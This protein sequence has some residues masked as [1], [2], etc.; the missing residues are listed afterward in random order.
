MK[1]KRIG[2]K[3]S[4][5][6]GFA[7]IA[8]VYVAAVVLAVAVFSLLPGQP[9]FLRILAAD[10]AATVFV[11]LA[12]M[13]VQNASVYDPYWSVQP[14]VIL[15]G[16]WLW[17]GYTSAGSALLLLVV[18]YWGVRLT[19]NWAVTFRCLAVQDW[20]YAM[21]REKYPRLFPLI[22][23][24]GIH[25]FPTVVV[26]LAVLPGVVFLQN[27]ALNFFTVLGAV[28]CAGAATL[29]MVADWQ[30]QR[31]RSSTGYKDRLMRT[32]L[33]RYSRHPNYLGEI[34]MWWGVYIMMLSAMPAAWRL[35]AGALANTLMFLF[36]SI[37]MA[38]ARGSREKPGYAAYRAETRMLLPLP[39][40]AGDAATQPAG[41][42]TKR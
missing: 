37:P 14:M 21:F 19:V 4:R 34:L 42:Q 18:L 10:V 2:F 23:L 36:V 27:S 7:Y 33:W 9:L 13:L 25:L 8:G 12:G 35:G 24:F 11:Y 5:A 31:F 26:Y 39:K 29:Q 16:V 1:E 28:V 22:S 15:L 3:Q 20:R 6:A 40:A 17:G 41:A 30:M 38:E 32:G